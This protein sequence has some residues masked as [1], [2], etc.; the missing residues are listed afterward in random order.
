M[1]ADEWQQEVNGTLHAV[2]LVCS[3]MIATHPERVKV[4]ALLQ[5]LAKQATDALASNPEKPHYMLGIQ[6]AVSTIQQSVD[7]ALLAEE[8]RAVKQQTGAH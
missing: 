4:L 8:V 2:V 6:R 3:T 1:T 5:E 7:T